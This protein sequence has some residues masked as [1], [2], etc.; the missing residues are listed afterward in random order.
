MAYRFDLEESGILSIET[1]GFWSDAEADAYLAELRDQIVQARR[2]HGA[3]LVLVDGRSAAVQSA[4][5]MEK[6][7]RIET[8]LIVS[9]RDRAAYVV[10]NSLSKLRRLAAT[11]QLEVFLSP[12]AART[13]LLAYHRP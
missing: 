5:V 4:S 7:A 3:A 11:D 1:S 9:D 12:S 10:A 13:W 2:L 6:V 8:I